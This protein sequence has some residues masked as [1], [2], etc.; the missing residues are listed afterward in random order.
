MQL[1]SKAV[2]RLKDEKK[3][4]E[5]RIKRKIDALRHAI[6]HLQPPIKVDDTWESVKPRLEQLPEFNAL[7]TEALQK[8][9]FEKHIQRLKVE[10]E[11]I[12]CFDLSSIFF[13]CI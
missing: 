9:A 4:Q 13:D 10:I 11:L 5:R 1:Q 12:V 2:H 8:E 7:D 6:K 3:R